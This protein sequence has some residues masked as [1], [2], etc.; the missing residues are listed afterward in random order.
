MRKITNYKGHE[1]IRVKTDLGE[2]RECD[3][4]TFEIYKDGK[5]IQ[6]ALTLGTAK[7]YISSGYKEIYL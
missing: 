5:Y 1:I 4:C 6:T 7:E 3:N 2:E